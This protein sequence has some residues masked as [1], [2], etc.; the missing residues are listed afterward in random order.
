MA[1]CSN[2]LINHE[3]A[4]EVV[5]GG[6]TPGADPGMRGGLRYEALGLLA[7]AKAAK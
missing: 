5:V 2:G 3:L 1:A 4:S 7:A 6:G